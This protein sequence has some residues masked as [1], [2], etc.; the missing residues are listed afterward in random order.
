MTINARATEFAEF[1][2]GMLGTDANR[3]LIL[4]D[5]A[6]N[7]ATISALLDAFKTCY[8]GPTPGPRFMQPTSN[9]GDPLATHREQ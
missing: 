3:P 6:V 5:A 8:P 7:G 9:G 1:C 2:A 4:G